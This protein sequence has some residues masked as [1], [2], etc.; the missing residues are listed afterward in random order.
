MQNGL[1]HGWRGFQLGVGGSDSDREYAWVLSILISTA[2][3]FI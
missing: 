2:E 1:G 3:G